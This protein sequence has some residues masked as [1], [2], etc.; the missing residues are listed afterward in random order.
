MG[1]RHNAQDFDLNRDCTKL[2]TSE[3]RSLARLMTEYDPHIAVDLH[4]TDGSAHGFYLTYQTSVS[5]N[6]S[7]GA[8]L[9][10]PQ[11]PVPVR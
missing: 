7:P 4:T 2:E 10:R 9:A 1:Q 3:A 8:D 11:R 5:P 6:T